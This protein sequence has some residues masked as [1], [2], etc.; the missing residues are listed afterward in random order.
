MHTS[1]VIL[2]TKAA[3]ITTFSISALAFALL[4]SYTTNEANASIGGPPAGRTGAPGESTCTSCHSS[5]PATGLMSISA[6]TTYVPGQT[7]TI[8]VVHATQDMS[9]RAWGFELTAL[10]AG[11][12]AAGTFANTTSFT[13]TRTG[14]NRFYVEQNTAGVFSG[15]SGGASWSFTWTAPTTDVGP[16]TIYAA[17]LQA[18]DDQGEGNDQTYTGTAVVQS[19]APVV[20]HHGFSDFDGDGRADKSVF[21]P[22]TGDWYI[23]RSTAGMTAL[24]WGLSSDRLAPAD[25]DGDDKTDVAVWR[26]V[27]STSADFYILQSLTSTVRVENFGITGDDPTVVGD[28]DG[29][30]KADPAVYRAGQQSYFYFRGS[31]NNPSNSITYLPWGING[32]VPIRADLDGDGKQDRA[33]FRPSSRLWYS[34]LS[35]TGQLRVDRWG[36]ETDRMVCADYDGD[37]KTDLAVFRNGTWIIRQSSTGVDL[38]VPFGSTG[39]IP[40]PADYDGDAKTDAAVYRNG[41]WYMRLSSTATMSAGQLGTASDTAIPSVY[42]K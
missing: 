27:S 13:R 16:V 3:L 25:F 40:V 2:A 6:P 31:L 1:K 14:N 4:S 33:V 8:Q 12:V 37:A 15:Q 23:D 18:D 9:R 7:Y 26:A 20:I 36:L 39:D 19:S 38:Y 5:N 11:N 17:G 28:W 34:L 41:T 35:G 29:D 21:R 24:H 42:V 32:D 30:G 10:S 22:S